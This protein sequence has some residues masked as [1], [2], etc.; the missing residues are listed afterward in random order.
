MFMFYLKCTLYT[1]L[2]P[3]RYICDQIL[4]HGT[5]QWNFCDEWFLHRSQILKE[6]IVIFHHNKYWQRL[7]FIFWYKTLTIS[8]WDG[9]MSKRQLMICAFVCLLFCFWKLSLHN[10]TFQCEG[11]NFILMSRMPGKWQAACF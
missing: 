10:T 6:S 9:R 2:F 8:S 11:S 3:L 4:S 1:C 7:S 5:F